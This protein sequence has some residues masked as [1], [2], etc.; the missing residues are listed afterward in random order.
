MEAGS[1]IPNRGDCDYTGNLRYRND[2]ESGPSE[3]WD[4]QN[5]GY[6]NYTG[7]PRNPTYFEMGQLRVYS[8]QY[9]WDVQNHESFSNTTGNFE[10][11]LS[12]EA[13]STT[14]RWDSFSTQGRGNFQV[15]FFS[16]NGYPPPQSVNPGAPS[17]FDNCDAGAV[18]GLI[19][20]NHNNSASFFT[21][22]STR[23][24]VA[25]HKSNFYDPV[26]D[27]YAPPDNRE[28]KDIKDSSSTDFVPSPKPTQSSP[29][30][31]V[32]TDIG[33]VIVDTLSAPPI[34]SDP[35][36]PPI[37][38]IE[39]Q[40]AKVQ[41]LV[42]NTS[43]LTAFQI[44]SQD[45][46]AL[47]SP[48]T[49]ILDSPIS[50][51]PLCSVQVYTPTYPLGPHYCHVLTFEP[52]DFTIEVLGSHVGDQAQIQVWPNG[53]KTVLPELRNK[54]IPGNILEAVSAVTEFETLSVICLGCKGGE[55]DGKSS[56]C[57]TS[58]AVHRSLP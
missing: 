46:F 35:S 49:P 50:P 8:P 26:R 48:L 33:Q 53:W 58:W 27:I 30:Q 47:D 45:E 38:N 55:V 52:N 28:F 11:I 54:T 56:E 24:H 41:S 18:P 14:G 12:R 21:E 39:T 5:R 40:S 36:N 10:P 20:G 3:R 44:E 17:S 51:A 57:G 2:F 32:R 34:L 31:T 37:S 16:H 13:G 25:T 6:A 42:C 9:Y 19:S 15:G 23:P 22:K 7:N 43:N 29:S 1:R 4:T